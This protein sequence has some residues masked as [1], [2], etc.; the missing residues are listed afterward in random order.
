M[1]DLKHTFFEMLDAFDHVRRRRS[2]CEAG[3]DSISD[4]MGEHKLPSSSVP[5]LSNVAFSVYDFYFQLDIILAKQSQNGEYTKVWILLVLIPSGPEKWPDCTC[6]LNCSV[7]KVQCYYHRLVYF[8]LQ[9]DNVGCEG[10]GML[11]VLLE[12]W[13]SQLQCPG[14]P[15]I[16]PS[17]PHLEDSTHINRIPANCTTP[18]GSFG[19]VNAPYEYP[20]SASRVL[21]CDGQHSYVLFG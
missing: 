17:H 16:H 8:W 18:F 20:E 6:T 13:Q 14:N 5:F 2:F 7:W 12:T 15:Q 4:I 3:R 21:T 10:F 11:S 19:G 1:S 9:A